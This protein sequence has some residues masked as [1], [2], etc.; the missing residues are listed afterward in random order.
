MPR[1]AK[2]GSSI[3]SRITLYAVI[4]TVTVLAMIVAICYG[5]FRSQL[6]QSIAKHQSDQIA[7]L[8]FQ[9]DDRLKIALHDLQK[10]ADSIGP[11]EL[12]DPDR[13]Q[14]ILDGKNEARTF[15]DN[16]YLVIGADCRLV[17]DSPFVAKRRG[18]DY[19]FRDYAVQTL[20]TGRP[21]IADPYVPVIPPYDPNVT[22]TA[23]IKR[24]DGKVI[25]LL[26]GRHNLL[27]G[28]FL[29][30]IIQTTV[31]DVGYLYII[32][33]KRTIVVH[34]D[35]NLIM[36]QIKLGA[37][38]GID[39][40]VQEG[41]EGSLENVDLRGVS[42]ITSFNHLNNVDWIIASHVPI[43]SIYKPLKSTERII[44]AAFVGISL[45]AALLIWSVLGR[46][47]MPLQQAINH[48]GTMS[49]KQGNE[50]FLPV[51]Y[52]GE[53]GRLAQVFNTL[54]DEFD[55]QQEAMRLSQETYLIV[56]EFTA[57]VAF[58]REPDGSIHFISPNCLDLTGYDESEFFAQPDLLDRIV[59]PDFREFWDGH[60]HEI[61]INSGKLQSSELKIITKCGDERWVSHLCHEVLDDKG[62][63]LGR[64]GNFTDITL[65]KQMQAELNGQKA[66]AEDLIN[67]AAVP[68][69]VLDINHRIIFWNNAIENLTGLR[70]EEMLGTD[71]QWV[72]FYEN[73]RPVLADLILSAD[74]S[75]LDELYDIY[76]MSQHVL[77]GLQAEGWLD[78]VGGQ[79]R[80]L[81]FDAAPVFD[82]NDVKR[83][84]VETLLDI[85]ER[86]L[87][88]AEL[89]KSREELQ[90][91]HNE[92]N[93][94]FSQVEIGKREWED[95]IDSLSE[96]V[97]LCDQFGVVSRCNRAV[98]SF[99]RL[100]YDEIVD[101]DCM[102]LFARVGL[103]ITGYNGTSGQMEC[104]EGQRHFEL[105]SNELKQIGSDE[106][107]GV[108]VTIHETTELF[109]MNDNLQ[110]AYAE[111]QQT[112]SQI[113]QQEKMASI[114]QLAAG[115]AHEINNPMAF[116]SSNLSSLGKYMEKI[117][118]FNAALQEA[119]QSKGNPDTLA[120][121]TEL[122][123]KMKIDFI[124]G[125]ISGLLAESHE[126]AERVRRIVQ[127]LKSFSHVDETECKPFSINDC[128]TSTLNMARNEIK[129]VAD[130]EQDYDPD[131]PLLN[132]YPQQLNQVFMNILVNAAHAIEGHGIIKIRTLLESDTIVV[133]ISDTGKG[134]SPENLTR[135]FEPFF[136]TKEV[137]KGTGLG[138][139]ISYDIIKKHGGII[140]VESEVGVGTTLIL[141][142]PLNHEFAQGS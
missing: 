49:K 74:E 5:L 122:R 42:G 75:Q 15:Y 133:R 116:I 80:Y 39:R 130:V 94:L 43:S 112:Q 51:G 52:E 25:G 129:Y 63:N 95:T 138:L 124:L 76:R 99:T 11:D 135:I 123:K 32:T 38:A 4:L 90:Q 113:L 22:F 102:E 56:A 12:S 85:T 61:N 72:P 107:R 136:T 26:A 142:L 82:A 55:N 58:W 8:A 115:V 87:F 44:I 27:K 40:A 18:R 114:G 104:E 67:K 101:V 105:L 69:F 37:N 1:V 118:I 91:K 47:M 10:I 139:S 128:L 71:R 9:V 106:I 68:I 88:E 137:G 111:L 20:K 92:L 140:I 131:L 34:P 23:P 16:G 77:G 19:S 64:R 86:K 73:K 30:S 93:E 127:D 31:S 21:Y 108:V 66:F 100:P 7:S 53:L 81:L 97:L 120:V 60:T 96:M 14:R 121:L 84:V 141:R 57:E 103:E 83:G 59:H 3:R 79:R 134:I 33:A 28:S 41:F 65:L 132:C 62:N 45:F 17:V 2:N 89:T 117:K 70:S 48:I 50:R 6:K 54:I 125:D 98:T 78:N 110:K 36:G 46:M 35:Q 109:K 24:A 29:R 119:V 13:L 126:G